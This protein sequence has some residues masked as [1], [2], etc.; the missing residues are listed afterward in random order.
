[1]SEHRYLKPHEIL[2][3]GDEFEYRVDGGRWSWEQV[4]V[5][6]VGCRVGDVFSV[7]RDRVRRKKE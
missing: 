1:M 2:Q 6:H 5:R 3:E 7:R 4:D